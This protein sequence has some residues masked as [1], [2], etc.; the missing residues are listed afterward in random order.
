MIHA[1]IRMKMSGQEV[2]EALEI[3]RPFAEWTKVQPGCIN[4]RIYRDVQETHVIMIEELWMT[5]QDLER[6]LRSDEYRDVLLV[7]E[8]SHDKPEIRF[9]A[10][11]H[12]T[13]IETI[14][15]A[16]NPAR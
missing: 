16:R 8:M 2:R 13:G 14:K 12:S 7:I 9:S 3:L 1:T 10:F 11:P 6:H 15:K 5:Q 4:F